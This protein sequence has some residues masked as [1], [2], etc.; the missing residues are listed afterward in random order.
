MSAALFIVLENVIPNFDSS[1]NGKALSKAEPTLRR[2][3]LDAGVKHLLDFYG[4]SDE[5]TAQEIYGES[6]DADL[7]KFKAK[8][9]AADEGLKTVYVLLKYIEENDNFIKNEVA[10]VREL[11]E[12]EHI[13]LEAKKRN[14]KWHLEVD[15]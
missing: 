8:W 2:I 13:L 1:T 7:T 4:A 15:Y 9:Y 10:I 6:L 14:V 3:A 11:K 12:L 5:E